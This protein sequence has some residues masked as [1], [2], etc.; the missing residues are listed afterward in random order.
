M[1]IHNGVFGSNDQDRPGI[2]WSFLWCC[3]LSFLLAPTE[4]RLLRTESHQDYP[5]FNNF[6]AAEASTGSIVRMNLAV[7]RRS[8][9]FTLCQG[10]QEPANAG[11]T[12]D[13]WHGGVEL[14]PLSLVCRYCNSCE[15]A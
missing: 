1:P 2:G 13:E 14:K 7:N 15:E 10:L 5:T 9:P 6:I 8:L 12:R 4:V 11:P 3:G